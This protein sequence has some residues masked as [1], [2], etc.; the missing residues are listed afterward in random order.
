MLKLAFVS[1]L[2]NNVL[3]IHIVIIV[4]VAVVI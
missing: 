4:V 1:G 3:I 2:V